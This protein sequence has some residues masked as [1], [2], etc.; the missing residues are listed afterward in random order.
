MCK[1]PL[2]SDDEMLTT[3]HNTL[4]SIRYK[5]G[6]ISFYSRNHFPSAD[7]LPNNIE[8]GHFVDV[9]HEVAQRFGHAETLPALINKKEWYK[10]LNASRICIAG[11][12]ETHYPNCSASKDVIA[13]QLNVLHE[14]G[15]SQAINALATVPYVPLWEFFA[16]RSD[17]NAQLKAIPHGA[18][19]Q[20]VR[21][22]YDLREWIG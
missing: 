18:I 3:F 5:D 17:I 1:T 15:T 20:I 16:P 10:H 9:S 19:I 13:A 14:E 11:E 2:A 12:D 7:W 6:D 22:R 21:P 4:I 8:A